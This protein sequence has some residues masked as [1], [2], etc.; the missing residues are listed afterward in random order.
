MWIVN[1]QVIN[2]QKDFTD[3]DGQRRMGSVLVTW[4]VA[5]LA[6]IGVK[7]F[8][9]DPIAKGYKSTGYTDAEDV[10]GTVVRTHAVVPIDTLADAKLN[11]IAEMNKAAYQLLQPTDYYVTRLTEKATAIPVAAVTERDQIR[12]D[13]VTNENAINALTTYDEVMAYVVVWT[14][15]V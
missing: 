6:G 8:R 2:R 14:E 3:G 13:V 10:D 9:E 15:I 7:P 11:R 12:T 1:G 4:S 5:A